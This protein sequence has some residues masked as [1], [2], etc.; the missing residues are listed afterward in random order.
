MKQERDLC[1]KCYR[2]QHMPAFLVCLSV[3]LALKIP[4][5]RARRPQNSC[6]RHPCARTHKHTKWPVLFLRYWS[7]P[8]S[9]LEGRIQRQQGAARCIECVR[10]CV[11]AKA[12]CLCSESGNAWSRKLCKLCGFTWC[13]SALP[14]PF[15][16]FFLHMCSRCI[17][18]V[19]GWGCTARY[20]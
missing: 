15:F 6:P 4:A 1:F 8:H 16:F 20:Q 17:V 5:L 18:T 19:S 11:C 7:A 2:E 3:C 12:A 13:I 9:S 10:L 14:L